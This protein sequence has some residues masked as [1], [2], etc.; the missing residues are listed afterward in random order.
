MERSEATTREHS[1]SVATCADGARLHRPRG[2]VRRRA[3]GMEVASTVDMRRGTKLVVLGTTVGIAMMLDARRRA[4]KTV[5]DDH[6]DT[7]VI[8]LPGISEVDPQPLTQVAA[9]AIDPDATR[10]AHEAIVEQRDRLP[11][12]GKNIP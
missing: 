4:R 6:E 7:Q 1:R 11:V 2:C 3:R 8:P 10:T 12:P 5:I 9:E